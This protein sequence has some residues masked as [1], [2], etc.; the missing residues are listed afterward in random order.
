[1]W[2]FFDASWLTSFFG[3]ILFFSFKILDASNYSQFFNFSGARLRVW[4]FALH[5]F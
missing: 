3:V 1:M 4:C 2:Q 5:R